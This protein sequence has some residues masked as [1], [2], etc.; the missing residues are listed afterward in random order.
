LS[1]CGRK[2]PPLP[3]LVRLPATVADLTARRLGD[4]VVL[5]FTVPVANADGSRPAD[6]D[7]VEL[8]AHT[9]PLPAPADFLK[10]GTLIAN[11]AVKPPAAA[12]GPNAVPGLEP[13]TKAVASEKITQAQMEIGRAPPVRTP[14]S[15]LKVPVVE[16]A[17]ETPGTVNA[18]LPTIRYY[19]AIGVSRRNRRSAFSIPLAVPLWSPMEALGVP[20]AQYT[21]GGLSL[22]W[23]PLA[24][25][26][27][28]FV[29][30]AVYNVYEVSERTPPEAAGSSGRSAETAAA[31]VAS[32]N[33]AAATSAAPPPLLKT[34]LNPVPLAEPAFKEPQVA[35]GVRRCYVVRAV[36][37]AGPISIES[38]PSPPACLI[39]ID[40]FPPE[41]PRELA[42]VASEG[43]VSLIW[44]PNSDKDLAGYRVL[45]GD[46]G[47]ATLTSVTP[48][49]IH[50]TTF[51]DTTVKSGTSYDY[52]VVAVDS[53]VP[54]NTSEYSNRQT[55]VV[56]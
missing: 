12:T 8:Y 42:A 27:D 6:I 32:T 35:F 1:S 56:P 10:Y 46:T 13:G 20:D 18:T 40:T 53:A 5:Q 9:G 31:A 4:E 39:P 49:L 52:V 22:T 51:R 17:Y 28:I 11:V 30:A 21:Q 23:T 48:E 7:R 19:A 25:A 14:G 24:R 38:E 3:P 34:P 47:A 29:P 45:R 50:E 26:E 2:G 37:M 55:V 15:R 54:P 33:A 16:P 36:R 41:P 44:E 43:A